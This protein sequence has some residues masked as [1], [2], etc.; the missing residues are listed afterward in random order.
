MDNL[1][2]RQATPTDSDFAYC[3]RRA[4]FREYVEKAGGW[5]E[6]RE[7]QNHERRFAAQEFRIISLAGVDV[8][9]TAMAFGPDCVHLYQ[10]FIL[11]EHQREGIGGAC[12]LLILDE[13]RRKRLPV[14]LRVYK[15]NARARAFY[16]RHGFVCTGE[17]DVHHLMEWRN[18]MPQPTE[19]P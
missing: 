17:D 11:P 3:T 19:Q 13:A 12:M 1:T 7:R 14:R 9:F 6:A 18:S 15:V 4:A 8:G 2:L 5:D 10:I 16:E